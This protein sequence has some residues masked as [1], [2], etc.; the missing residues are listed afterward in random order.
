MEGT[1]SRPSQGPGPRILRGV[2]VLR[3]SVY[4][5]GCIRTWK[6]SRVSPR[7]AIPT[8]AGLPEQC[9]DWVGREW[10]DGCRLEPDKVRVQTE[11]GGRTVL[12]RPRLSNETIAYEVRT[13]SREPYTNN[14]VCAD[15][16]HTMPLSSVDAVETRQ[17]A[18]VPSI[19]VWWGG[20][21]LVSY[22]LR[23]VVWGSDR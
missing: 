18:V 14:K 20:I 5:A 4:L 2:V 13:C 7:Q 3:A 15:S 9:R 21:A 11:G 23:P 1:T 6:P 16:S 19:L 8:A 12:L 10:A 22:S 17:V